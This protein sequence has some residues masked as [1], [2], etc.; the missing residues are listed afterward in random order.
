MLIC[1]S[2]PSNVSLHKLFLNYLVDGQEYYYDLLAYS[3]DST[4]PVWCRDLPLNHIQVSS[5]VLLHRT[6]NEHSIDLVGYTTFHLD[7]SWVKDR[8]CKDKWSGQGDQLSAFCIVGSKI[9]EADR[10]LLPS[11]YRRRAPHT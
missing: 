7:C 8:L 9:K 4:V 3:E 5:K 10:G 1:G 6:C 11:S 2:V